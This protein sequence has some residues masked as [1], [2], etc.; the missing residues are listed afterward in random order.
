LAYLLWLIKIVLLTVLTVIVLLLVNYCSMYWG[1]SNEGAIGSSCR[2]DQK[3]QRQIAVE[4]YKI[5]QGKKIALPL[6]EAS[7]LQHQP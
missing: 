7:C 1:S 3:L 5:E 6:S 4:H 2:Y